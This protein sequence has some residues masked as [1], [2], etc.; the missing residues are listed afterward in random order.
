MRYRLRTL[1]VLMGAAPLWIYVIAIIA[2]SNRAGR[3]DSKS[4][5]ITHILLGG[6]AAALYRLTR[7]LPE[8]LAIAILL[9]PMI[10]LGSLLVASVLAG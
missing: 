2:T 10:A 4:L 9:A 7:R 8:G 3:F 6:I 1:L 5:I